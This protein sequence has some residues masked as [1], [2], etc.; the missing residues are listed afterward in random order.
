MNASAACMRFAESEYAAHPRELE[1][2]Q[3]TK[4]AAEGQSGMQ[5]LSH[6]RHRRPSSTIYPAIPESHHH[7]DE[8][9]RSTTIPELTSLTLCIRPDTCYFPPPTNRSISH[10]E[11]RQHWYAIRIMDTDDRPQQKVCFKSGDYKPKV[12]RVR[13][14]TR[15]EAR[16]VY[17][18]SKPG[19]VGVNGQTGCH[20]RE[21]ARAGEDRTPD[22]RWEGLSGKTRIWPKLPGRKESRFCRFPPNSEWPQRKSLNFPRAPERPQKIAKNH[23]K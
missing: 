14:K 12:L 10:S 7:Q 4:Q 21:R 19:A 6:V 5:Q 18:P 20:R 3:P 9:D 22:N 16:M 2:L 1:H 11:T 17:N 13:M 23:E 15:K 8:P